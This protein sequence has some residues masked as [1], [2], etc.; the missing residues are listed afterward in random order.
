MCHN[1]NFNEDEALKLI[2]QIDL[3]QE[4]ESSEQFGFS[5]TTILIEEAIDNYN[6][7]MLQLL[8]DNGANPNKIYDCQNSLWNLQYNYG[9]TKEQNKCRLKMAQFLLEHG[10]N[11]NIV[12]D[13][14]GEDLFSWI[15]YEVFY[16]DYDELYL[17]RLKFFILLVAYGGKNKYCV[18]D[19]VGKFNKSNMSQYKLYKRLGECV[20][21]D[22]YGN[23]IA[24][25]KV[26]S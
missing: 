19:I 5:H 24:W 22:E 16:G 4:F 20:I 10:A 25:I 1:P 18:P 14:S 13:A 23:A 8:L 9:E 12:T 15:L 7:K 3:N 26:N 17:Y 6:F 2:K 21:T 11:P